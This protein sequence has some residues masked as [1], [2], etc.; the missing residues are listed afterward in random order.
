MATKKTSTT[1]GWIWRISGKAKW[2]A[3]LLTVIRVLQGFTGIQYAFFLSNVVDSAAAGDK[4]AF[5]HHLLRFVV[6][7]VVSVALACLGRYFSE[8]SKARL[9]Q[10]F[11]MRAFSQLMRRDFGLVSK[12]HS[13]AWMNRVTSDSYVI[14][15]AVA[16]IV[17]E[18]AG[19][20]VRLIGSLVSLLRIVPQV[21][22]LL[23][24]CGA[25]ML[26]CSLFLRKRIKHYHK[27]V[28]D[29]D[30]N[31]RAFMQE[32]LLSL[33]VV[34]TFTQEKATETMATEKDE[35][36]VTARMRRAHLVNLCTT[37]IGGAMMAAQ[38]IGIAICGWGILNGLITYGT[39]S[40]TLYLVSMLE[41]PLSK[42]SSYFAQFYSMLASAERLMDIE[43]FPLDTALEP[44]PEDAV[45]AY[46]E[47]RFQSLG[48]KD[49]CFRYE[50]DTDAVLQNF[51]L[52]IRKGEFVAF[53]G[54]SGCGKS[55]TLK[56][57]LR[58][59]PLSSGSVY[60]RNTDGTEQTLDAAWRGMFAYVPQGNMLMSG[61]IRETITFADPQR[62]AQEERIWQALRIAC[63]DKFVKELPR[64]L[65]STLRECGSGLSE[66][67]MQ[68]LSIARAILS[69]RPVL[70]LDE[71][72]SALDGATETQLLK[73][74]RAMTDRT[75]LIIT[76]REAVLDFCDK[77]I[78]F[79]KKPEA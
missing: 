19:S 34:R 41:D 46:Y 64:G 24:P 17:P 12:T 52:D 48:L 4:E 38:L 21:V 78:H 74:L 44:V 31:S 67:Q 63:A 40:A 13:G 2:W 3:A 73:N 47:E 42:I 71:A 54:E 66:G 57:L 29:T 30:S 65:D 45:Q 35:E 26:F 62:M 59:Y 27:D 28:Q 37:A 49:A 58:L 60:L 70:L 55:T 79:E 5:G 61:S 68:R 75:V 16:M 1:L 39:M 56:V 33:L 32:R 8:K 50:D 72:T 77:R 22:Y 18:T 53:T 51:S 23:V 9:D 15:G 6:L 10:S 25:L 69:G 11:R 7:V 76:H 20:L 43:D 14:A 36:V